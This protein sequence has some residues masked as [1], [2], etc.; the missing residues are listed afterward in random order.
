MSPSVFRVLQGYG[1]P[2]YFMFCPEFVSVGREK[3]GKMDKDLIDVSPDK[4]IVFLYVTWV[5]ENF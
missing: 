4:E 2:V 1:V 3:D 5:Q